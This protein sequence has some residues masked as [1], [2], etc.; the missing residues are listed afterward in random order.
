MDAWD[1]HVLKIRLGLVHGVEDMVFAVSQ[2]V[3]SISHLVLESI[4]LT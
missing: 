1:A 3:N 4:K 2:M